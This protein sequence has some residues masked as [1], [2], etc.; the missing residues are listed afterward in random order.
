MK[1][2]SD[3]FIT[4]N[5]HSINNEVDSKY[6][7]NDKNDDNNNNDNNNNNVIDSSNT[8]DKNHNHKVKII[9]PVTKDPVM[10]IV[11]PHR[12]VSTKNICNMD[13]LLPEYRLW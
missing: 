4:F 1:S 5:H 6:N 7:H 12:P 3:P 10:N 11:S 13:W 8:N 2:V 9:V